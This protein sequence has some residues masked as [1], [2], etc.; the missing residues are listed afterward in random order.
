MKL[1]EIKGVGKVTLS[2]LH[3]LKIMTVED[4]LFCF[5]KKYEINTLDYIE[6]RELD[7]N[8]SLRVEVKSKPKLYYIRKRLTKLTFL[9]K[10][11]NISFG[12]A[13]FN[14]EYL[15][16]SINPGNEIVITGKFLKNYNSFSASNIVFY[17]NYKEGIIP[18]YNLNEITE[19]RVSNI[20]E[21]ILNYGCELTDNLPEYLKNKHKFSNINN[22]LKKIHKPEDLSDVN[23]A[24]KR[25]AY[26]EFLMFAI[27]VEAIKKLNERIFTPKKNYDLLKVKELIATLPFEMTNDQKQ[28]TNE[29][30]IDFKKDSRMNRLLQGDVGSG[31]T[32]VA[33]ISSYAVVTAH[34]QVAILAPTLVLA[35]QHYD[36]FTSYL[37]K[38]NV[39][40]ALL[41]SD[42]TPSESRNIISD[43]KN[44]IIDIIIG[45]HSL[46][47]DEIT[48]DNLGFVVIDEQQRFGVRQ[49]KVI[50]QKGINPDILMMSATPIPRT[51]AI[52]LFENT[53]VSTI[54]EKP[55]NR[56]NIET[57]IIDFEELEFAF[58]VI[59]DELKKN[60]QIYVICPLIEYNEN[61]NHIA[62]EEAINIINK[63]FATAKTDILHGKMADIEKTKVLNKFYD[64]QTQILISTTVVEVGVNIRNAS[65]MI[66]FNANAFG[67]AQVHQLRGRIGRN[68]FSA[69]CFLVVND[70]L[71]ETER[72][73]ILETTNDGFEISEYDL[74]I[75]GPGEVFGSMQSGVPNFRFANIINDI[76]LRDFAFE[77]AKILLSKNDPISKRLVS[78]VLKTIDSY[79]LD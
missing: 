19:Y 24:I 61:R 68:D 70:L 77:D 18:I 45:T 1:S 17:S 47:Q 4:M 16:N 73:K 25:M 30:F 39:K 62:V 35:K 5:P 63:R 66:I 67:L 65:T 26:E 79:N 56:K 2:K 52:S 29:I 38:F 72:L 7:K 46:L 55:S 33:I 59:E 22:I 9:V 42:T 57:K 40:I 71:E 76:E 31:K 58:K 69:H 14:R 49:R 15:A 27:K 37:N 21:N 54:R 8:L 48:F 43:V 64:N 6:N 74:A 75:R 28:V 20:I 11:N 23:L 50:R 3:E 41:T 51:L 36:T 13:I 34:Y 10:S 32:I 60:R 78:Q 53:E 12:V 44:H